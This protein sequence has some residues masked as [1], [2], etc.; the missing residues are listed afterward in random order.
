MMCHFKAY[1]GSIPCGQLAGV[2]GAFKISKWLKK[3][4]MID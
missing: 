2:L 4:E 3:I 1:F